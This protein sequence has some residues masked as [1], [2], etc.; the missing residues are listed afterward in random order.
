MYCLEEDLESVLGFYE[1]SESHH[2]S[3]KTANII[4]RCLKEFKRR[5]RAMDSFPNEDYCLRC[6]FMICMEMNDSWARRGVYNF[7]IEMEEVLNAA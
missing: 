2:V 1:F 5:T 3:I 7:G 4:E 6:I